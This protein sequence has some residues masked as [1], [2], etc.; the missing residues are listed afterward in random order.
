MSKSSAKLH[1]YLTMTAMMESVFRGL[2]R[3]LG[4]LFQKIMDKVLPT[5]T[6]PTSQCSGENINISKVGKFLKYYFLNHI[7]I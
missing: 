2:Y 5:L 1:P 4:D 3:M 6:V 7:H